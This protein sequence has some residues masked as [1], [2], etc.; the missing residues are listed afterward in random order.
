MC[1]SVNGGAA[2]DHNDDE[3][4]S[5]LASTVLSDDDD[6]A[7]VT[8]PNDKQ[9][10]YGSAVGQA[11]NDKKPRTAKATGSLVKQPEAMQS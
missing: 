1:S 11:V 8:K 6:D 9:Q 5:L 10:K 2:T 3:R 4:Q 7:N